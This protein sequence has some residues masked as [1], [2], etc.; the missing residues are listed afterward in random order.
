MKAIQ[1]KSA[2]F[3]LTLINSAAS[4][5]QNKV[6][7]VGDTGKERFND[8][9]ML[10]DGTA[11][12]AGQAE[13]L[14][15][16]PA[17]TPRINLSAT[18]LDSAANGQ[19]AFILHTNGDFSQ[20]LR[21]VTLPSASAR[22]VFKIRSTE[23]PGNATGSIFISGSRDGGS[24]DGYF[25]AKL[26]QNF[27][28]A[29]PTALSYV[30]NVGAAA[31]HKERQPWDVGG[32]GKVVYALGRAFDPNWAAIQKLGVDGQPEVV[33]NWTAHWRANNGGEWDG[34][35]ASSYNQALPLA[36]SA[37]VMKGTRRGSLR[38]T[39]ATDFAF[40][41]IDANGNAGRKGKFP[42]DYYFNSH[43]EL[44]GTNTCPSSGPGYT[45]YQIQGIQTQRVG[46]IVID[47][48]NN[49]LYFGYSTKSTLP[50]G[51]PDFEPAVV[52][53]SAN[54]QMRW[55]DRLYH[56]TT[57][58][59]SPDQ[60][61]DGLALDHNNNRLIILG[62]SHGNNVKNFWN[63]DQIAVNP[64]AL[65]FQK[66]FTG[67]NGN[68]HFS[69]LGSYSLAGRVQASTYLGEYV[70]GS[71]N[72]G[73]A[74]VDAHYAGWP[75]PN[76]GWPDFNT[77]R[78]GADATQSGEIA[79]AT[80]GSVAVTCLGRRTFTTLDAYIAMP[81]PNQSP[82][83]ASAWN[84]FVRVYAPDFSAVKYSSLIVGTWDQATGAGG[85]NTWLAGIAFQ[86][87]NIVAVGMHKADA[88]TPINALGANVPAVS[89]PSWGVSAPL[90]QSAL[91]ARL[92][93]T[94]LGTPAG[95]D[96]FANGFE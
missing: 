44:A 88:T 31:D 67:T 61:V 19:Q 71:T 47:R 39:N 38:S 25:V 58:N 26:D 24:T 1:V 37:I 48:R 84:Q 4:M 93:G 35:P 22:D 65:S 34:T 80:D 60:Y 18:G 76:L 5:A 21:V 69:W 41:S 2:F 17:N 10:S 27:V 95:F 16:L 74:L 75:N 87:A 92:S 79:V 81:R 51:N 15:W 23:V 13:S 57:A 29:L 53:M 82:R 64:G 12:I 42:D 50:G 36:Y 45:N 30:Y 78:C 59:S 73:A 77:T 7:Y 6:F 40:T 96:R 3:A 33:E 11:L 46:A 89:V 55:W 85:D 56:E 70:D 86:G 66:Q 91:F 14:N 52:A 49:D 83:P 9:H 54:G 43:C 72:Y 8:V 20:I 62:R 90:S 63:G 32:D 68:I 28:S 94:R